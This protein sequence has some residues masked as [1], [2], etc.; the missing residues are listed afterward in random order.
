MTTYAVE[1]FA[2]ASEVIKMAQDAGIE[3]KPLVREVRRDGQI[4]RSEYGVKIGPVNYYDKMQ[5]SYAI[6]LL[7][8]GSRW[9]VWRSDGLYGR[10][11]DHWNIGWR[12][13]VRDIEATVKNGLP[14]AMEV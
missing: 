6:V 7:D 8:D 5:M 9:D 4:V 2:K 14:E 12:D 10:W 11:N 13:V 3:V 1:K